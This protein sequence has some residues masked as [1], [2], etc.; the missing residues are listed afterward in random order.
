MNF[1][2]PLKFNSDLLDK[3]RQ[4]DLFEEKLKIL[5]EQSLLFQKLNSTEDLKKGS[6]L[7]AK[8]SISIASTLSVACG[9]IPFPFADIPQVIGIEVSMVFSIA[10]CYGFKPSDFNIFKVFESNGED[11]GVSDN[12]H[13]NFISISRLIKEVSK[14]IIS[15]VTE[16][17]L[18]K[19]S[20]LIKYIPVVGTIIGGFAS[21]LINAGFTANFGKNCLKSFEKNLLGNDHGFTYL[22]NRIDIYKDIFSQISFLSQK[23]NWDF[24]IE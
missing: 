9:F 17:G 10:A 16:S 7:K 1:L 5:Q 15:E 8:V 22:K 18:K 6:N 19:T 3:I 13:I 14:E 23:E 21:S 24:E 20:E 2:E 11:I 4:P 12:R